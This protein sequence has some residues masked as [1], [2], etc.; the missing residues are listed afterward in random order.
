MSPDDFIEKIL[1]NK[2]KIKLAVVG[3]NYRL[4][5]W[6]RRCGIP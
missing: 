6:A 5:I 3:F 4:D 1:I 2:L